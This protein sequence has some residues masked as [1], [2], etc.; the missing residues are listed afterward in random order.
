MEHITTKQFLDGFWNE[1]LEEEKHPDLYRPLPA[2]V[3]ELTSAIGG[4]APGYFGV[5][6]APPKGGKSA[7]LMSSAT[8]IAKIK[9]TALMGYISNEMWR[10][11]LG[12]SLMANIAHVDR[13]RIQQFELEEGEKRKIEEAK[14]DIGVGINAHW[15]WNITKMDDI[16]K[17]ILEVQE[18]TGERMEFIIIDY[19]H[20]MEAPGNTMIQQIPWITRRMKQLT[21]KFE[22]IMVL[23][24]AQL[25]Q[26]HIKAKRWDQTAFLYGGV[27]LD[28]DWA[29][30]IAPHYDDYDRKVEG[31]R[32]LHAAVVREGK[33]G[34][35]HA[36]FRGEYSLLTALQPETHTEI[37][38][39]VKNL[40]F[41][42]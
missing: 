20:L 7:A 19:I 23:S 24:A 32:E 16:E 28:A 3:P 6:G 41:V 40:E 22:G 30:I 4:Y 17:W 26:E 29:V 1:Y 25:N 5:Y 10:K 38:Q 35:V 39:M 37:D 11:Q 31:R 13:T 12:R 8:H 14:R 27:Q 33:G 36:A 2:I 18:A 9:P 34:M 15:A 21:Q 42:V